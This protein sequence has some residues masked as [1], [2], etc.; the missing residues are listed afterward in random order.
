MFREEEDL[1]IINRLNKHSEMINKREEKNLMIPI[2]IVSIQGEAKKL[3]I[4]N[5]P[6]FCK[7]E[8]LNV[9]ENEGSLISNGDY[10]LFVDE[11]SETGFVK[12]YLFGAEYSESIGR[13]EFKKDWFILC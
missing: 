9:D 13:D 8:G 6:I 2:T 1:N 4:S 12:L 5:T 10:T 3:G 7:I 11:I